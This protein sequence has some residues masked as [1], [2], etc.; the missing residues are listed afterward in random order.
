[1]AILSKI[2][3]LR[4]ETGT[5][6]LVAIPLLMSLIIGGSLM[7]D[8]A[9]G[10]GVRVMNAPLVIADVEPV[11]LR[12]AHERTP[13]KAID[14]AAAPALN[15]QLVL[16]VD[17][18]GFD[19]IDVDIETSSP[20]AFYM[21]FYYWMKDD[22]DLPITDSYYSLRLAND[23]DARGRRFVNRFE[24]LPVNRRADKLH[25]MIFPEPPPSMAVHELAFFGRS[26]AADEQAAHNGTTIEGYRNGQA[27]SLLGA[28]EVTAEFAARRENDTDAKIAA[29]G[30]VIELEN[31]RSI[32]QIGLDHRPAELPL[33]PT[34]IGKFA[35][36]TLVLVDGAGDV[37]TIGTQG[38]DLIE[39]DRREGQASIT[40]YEY[41][42]SERTH[43]FKKRRIDDDGVRMNI[44]AGLT[45]RLPKG[46]LTIFQHEGDEVAFLSRHAAGHLATLTIGEHA[47]HVI[48]ENDPLI[49]FGHDDG[50]TRID[51]MGFIG[52]DIPISRTVFGTGGSGLSKGIRHR[53]K[54]WQDE[55]TPRV[56]EKVPSLETSAELRRL[57]DL[58]RET[59]AAIE[60]GPHSAAMSR[61]DVPEG[62]KTR[63][64]MRRALDHVQ[65]YEPRI[66]I[67]H[68]GLEVLH[69]FGWDRDDSDYYT[70]DLLLD[71]GIDYLSPFADKVSGG[72]SMLYSDHPSNVFYTLPSIVDDDQTRPEPYF[73]AQ[74]QLTWDETAFS[75]EALEAMADQ[76]GFLNLHTYLGHDVT[77]PKF[78][79]G[80]QFHGAYTLVPW[81]NEHLGNLDAMRDRGDLW[82]GLNSELYDFH[83]GLDHLSIIWRDGCI[84]LEGAGAEPID[85]VTLAVTRFEDGKWATAKPPWGSLSAITGRRESDQ[86]DYLWFDMSPNGGKKLCP[87]GDPLT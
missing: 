57:F 81:F 72:N 10:R 37:S 84:E 32:Y 9:A 59:G 52:N 63:E 54:A 31:L 87:N 49:M 76:R 80:G 12:L 39:V 50:E 38:A 67:D 28:N 86:I 60:Y 65:P 68:G 45:Q 79:E 85:G 20:S 25:R 44:N 19:V 75:A 51:G 47:D 41:H 74:K 23:P 7:R 56:S 66:S 62:T 43:H 61:A 17:V 78:E 55:N 18:E 27:A 35:P 69:V 22:I 30:L 26:L 64:T 14:P 16:D 21:H 33:G 11:F 24:A 15:G 53:R 42:F 36:K 40:V 70:L 29:R 2:R 34:V 8:K 48:V 71:A 83:R 77:L 6:L 5:L 73:F 3:G 1:M 46:K 13:I 4:A 82:L 58:Y